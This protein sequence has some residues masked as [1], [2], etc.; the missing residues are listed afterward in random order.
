MKQSQ[1]R[2]QGL[3]KHLLLLPLLLV[4]ALAMVACGQ[5]EPEAVVPADTGAVVVD[6][7]AVD[8]AAVVEQEVVVDEVDAV[9]TTVVTETIVDTDVITEIEVLTQTDTATVRIVTEVMTD[10]DVMVE[11]DTTTESD[12]T[13]RTEDV[14]TGQAF[15]IIV[16]ADAAG[17]Q[18]LG[19]PLS[20]RPVFASESEA[21]T[22]DPRF[23]AITAGEATLL[24]EGLDQNRIGEIDR[25]GVRQLTYN[26]RPL[27][28]FTGEEN[29]DWRTP[30]GELGLWPLTAEGDFGDF[31]D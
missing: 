1:S 18:F 7:T 20:Q 22:V 2:S 26:N 6:E 15:A 31:T 28:R 16:I 30:A 29:E 19:D 5:D 4:L 14:D 3:R 12:V 17:N 24:G 11:T 8:E 21:L 9:A 13:V 27:Y 23:E 25:D 10:T